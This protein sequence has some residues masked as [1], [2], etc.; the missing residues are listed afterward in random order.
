MAVNED[1]LLVENEG[2]TVP[3]QPQFRRDR[4][5]ALD[6]ERPFL[7]A[8]E[9]TRGATRL[10]SSH[11]ADRLN[12]TGRQDS[13]NRLNSTHQIHSTEQFNSTDHP[14]TRQNI[15]WIAAALAFVVLLAV[16][17]WKNEV[18]TPRPTELTA[19]EQTLIKRQLG[20]YYATIASL[21]DANVGVSVSPDEMKTIVLPFE[22]SKVSNGNTLDFVAPLLEQLEADVDFTDSGRE[23]AAKDLE[24]ELSRVA[25]IRDETT[26]PKYSDAE[27]EE[28]HAT[29]HV[30][31]T[32]DGRF[33]GQLLF[34]E[35]NVEAYTHPPSG[36]VYV[37]SGSEMSGTGP[38]PVRL[39]TQGAT[40][41]AL[42]NRETQS[43]EAIDLLT[44]TESFDST[45]FG[46]SLPFS[47]K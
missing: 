26:Q 44:M 45:N 41:A 38:S 4:R 21:Y 31:E 7:V 15:L 5:L 39:S 10:S 23:S 2:S 24:S 35:M 22:A 19:A 46:H 13:N 20:I 8:P 6:G 11:R 43:F 40:V 30:L 3:P 14:N 32:N 28:L 18:D 33:I 16:A 17:I 47:T 29:P 1:Q 25:N 34:S 42:F 36:Y 37:V 9:E 12:S 27:K